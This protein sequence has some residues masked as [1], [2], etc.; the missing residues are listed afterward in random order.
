MAPRSLTQGL[1]PHERI[2]L[3][4][5]KSD[6]NEH[7][8]KKLEKL[9]PHIGIVKL[10]YQAIYSRSPLST[11]ALDVVHY[12]GGPMFCDYFLDAKLK[13]IQNTVTEAIKAILEW[14]SPPKIITIHATMRLGTIVAALKATKP[15]TLIAG[16]TLLTDHDDADAMA[17][18]GKSAEQVV[19]DC[20]DRLLAASR[21]TGVPVAMVSGPPDLLALQNGGAY[22]D[23]IKITPG[24]RD[25]N[26]KPDDQKRTMTA[27]EAISAG[28]DYLV[29]GR[30][31]LNALDEVAAAQEIA[32]QIESVL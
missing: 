14:H 5:D 16:V 17:I 22:D 32:E 20:A 18:Y 26:A 3:P 10:G 27:A 21:A 19:I 6:F 15:G 28:A 31:I 1:K 29:I 9:L 30:P 11:V 4:W 7:N 24:I 23:L 12:L 2:I 8:K 13:D 25:K